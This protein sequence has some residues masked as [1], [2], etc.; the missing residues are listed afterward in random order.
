MDIIVIFI[1]FWLVCSILSYL[2]CRFGYRLDSEVYTKGI[3]EKTL[4]FILH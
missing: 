4:Y 3:D 2:I 1:L